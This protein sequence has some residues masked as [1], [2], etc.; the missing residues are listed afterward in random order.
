M[1]WVCIYTHLEKKFCSSKIPYWLLL[2]NSFLICHQLNP[3]QLQ[4]YIKSTCDDHLQSLSA[5]SKFSDSAELETS[6]RTWNQQLSGFHP[7]QL[8]LLLHAVSDTLPIEMNL[9][10]WNIQCSAKCNHCDSTCPTNAHVLSRCPAASSHVDMACQSI[11]CSHLYTD[12][13]NLQ[14]SGSPPTTLPI[15]VLVTPFGPDMVIHNTI[16]SN[17]T[18]FEL[19]CPLDSNHHINYK[20]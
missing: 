6:C 20:F 11:I 1:N 10:R 19:T 16:T 5:Q 3:N 15:D 9:H 13:S 14:A 17:L 12:L 7:G 4:N 8:S 18:L 2:R